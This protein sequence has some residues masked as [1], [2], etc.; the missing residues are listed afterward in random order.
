MSKSRAKDGCFQCG[1]KEHWKKNGSIW[2]EKRNKGNKALDIVEV[3]TNTDGELL[4]VDSKANSNLLAISSGRS[5]SYWILDFGCTYHSVQ[6]GSFVIMKGEIPSNLL[7]TLRGVTRTSGAIISTSKDLEDDT[8]LWYSRLWHI[9]ERA[10]QK[11]HNRKLLKGV[12]SCKLQLCKYCNMGKQSR[13]VSSKT[14]RTRAHVC[15]IIFT[16][17]YGANTG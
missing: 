11:L 5:S 13:M 17:T 15:Q 4:C 3:T 1:S 9:S 12:H 6:M 2:K 7:Y 14:R 8:Q 16:K 10:M